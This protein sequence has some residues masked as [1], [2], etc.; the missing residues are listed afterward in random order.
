MLGGKG[1]T[2]GDGDIVEEL[3]LHDVRRIKLPHITRLP[4]TIHIR[5]RQCNPGGVDA[6][7]GKLPRQFDWNQQHSLQ[8]HPRSHLSEAQQTL[9]LQHLPRH[10]WSLHGSHQ[11][12]QSSLDI[13]VW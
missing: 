7:P 1:N 12:L 3:G 10:L 8:N 2:E 6:S 4:H 5:P 9:S 11:L 13:S